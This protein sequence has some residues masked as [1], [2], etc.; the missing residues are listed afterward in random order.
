[1][2][3]V[4]LIQDYCILIIIGL[5][6]RR[7]PEEA[8]DNKVGRFRRTFS[9]DSLGNVDKNLYNRSRRDPLSKDYKRDDLHHSTLYTMDA[10]NNKVWVDT[11][12]YTNQALDADGQ[13]IESKQIADP[14]NLYGTILENPGQDLDMGFS[15]SKGGHN[16]IRGHTDRNRLLS[17]K[18]LMFTLIHYVG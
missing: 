2:V 11:T 6:T 12:V 7:R 18:E 14:D 9:Y 5:T 4:K 16:A 10:N 15:N 1:M 13:P 3:D 8:G 17:K